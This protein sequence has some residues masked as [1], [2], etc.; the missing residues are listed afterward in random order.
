MVRGQLAGLLAGTG[1]EEIPATGEAFDPTVHEAIAAMPSP[2]HSEGT[3]IEVVEKGYRHAEHVLRPSRVVIAAG[4]SRSRRGQG[5]ERT[6]VDDLYATLGVAKTASADEI[7][8]AYRKLARVHHPDA[9]AGDPKAEERFKEISHAHDVLSDP[10]KRQEYDARAVRRPAP[11]RRPPGRRRRR[12]RRLRR[13]RRHVLDD[14]PR[15]PRRRD[16]RRREPRARAAGAD[17]EVEVNL[18]FDQAMAG[19]QV[20]VSVETPVAC[21]DCGGS[22]AKPGTA[23]ACAPS[24][25]AAACAAATAG[26]SRSASPARG[27]AATAR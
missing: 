13:L 5:R 23:R 20:P 17:V 4:D 22:G 21:A 24:A 1:V 6:R 18:S 3:V 26:R 19:A 16:G 8:K 10:E 25:R 7:K 9:N 14:L 27:A 12:R 15:R 11:E 2:D